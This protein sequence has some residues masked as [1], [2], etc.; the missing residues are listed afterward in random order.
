M[1]IEV[2]DRD[3]DKQVIEKSKEVPV[4]VDFWAGWCMPCMMLSPV[5]ESLAKEYKGKFILAK[6]DVDRNREKAQE[7]GVMGIPAVKMFKKGRMVDEF[8]GVVPEDA[9]RKWLDKNI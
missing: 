7:Y 2:N 6:I 1:E 3:F 5:L 9:V 4:V 8:V